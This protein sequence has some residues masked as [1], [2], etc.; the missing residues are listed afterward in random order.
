M[1]LY[2]SHDRTRTCTIYFDFF[3]FTPPNACRRSLTN[4]I[5]LSAFID[6]YQ[7]VALT[8]LSVYQFRH[9]TKTVCFLIIPRT[10]KL[11]RHTI[12]KECTLIKKYRSILTNVQEVILIFDPYSALS[13]GLFVVRTGLEPVYGFAW[14]LRPNTTLLDASTNSAT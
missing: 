5:Y 3:I 1:F 11:C 6:Y 8:V 2:C 7:K 12:R 13:R 4:T 14:D 9:M 10:H